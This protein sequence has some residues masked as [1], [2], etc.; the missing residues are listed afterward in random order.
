MNTCEKCGKQIDDKYEYC[1]DCHLKIGNEALAHLE[2][3]SCAICHETMYSMKWPETLCCNC[4]SH[5]QSIKKKMCAKKR[6]DFSTIET[7]DLEV[8]IL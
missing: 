7:Q 3:F 5:S 2:L 8:D 6:S 1:W 4:Y